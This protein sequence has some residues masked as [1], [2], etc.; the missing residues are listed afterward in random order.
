MREF[1]TDIAARAE[2]HG[3]NPADIKILW[4]AQPL[5]A[6][7]TTEAKERAE[8]IRARIPLEASLALM[9]S[10]FNVDL[11]P[12]DVDTP[13]SQLNLNVS[14]LQGILDLYRQT[15]P[16]VT[17]RY[18][19]AR[20]LSGSDRN[21]FV[22]TPEEVAD[23]MQQFLEEGGGDGFQITPS[24]YA[25]DYYADLVNL[26]VPVLQKRGVFRTEY[27]GQTLRERMTRG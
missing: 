14:G 9:S 5:V 6:K 26:L 15:N 4:G 12:F 24:Y 8:E 2:R 13:L 22:G 21:P 11:S 17:L 18:V 7:T 25:P 1:C 20:Y 23:A 10:H 19:A 16:N 27:T 3:R